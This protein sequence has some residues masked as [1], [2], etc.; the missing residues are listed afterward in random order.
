MMMLDKIDKYNADGGTWDIW[1]K[2]AKLESKRP[3]TKRG[4]AE[5][6]PASRLWCHV[7]LAHTFR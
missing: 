3:G 7:F 5:D 1:N 6:S 4:P 2:F